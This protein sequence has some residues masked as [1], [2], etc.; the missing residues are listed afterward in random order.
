MLTPERLAAELKERKEIEIGS[1]LLGTGGGVAERRLRFLSLIV[2]IFLRDQNPPI[3][4]L[5][6]RES[7]CDNVDENRRQPWSH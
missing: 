4:G 7:S 1:D 6:C 2:N 5:I 3:I